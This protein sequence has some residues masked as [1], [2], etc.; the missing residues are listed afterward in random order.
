MTKCDKC[1]KNSYVI[2]IDKDHNKLCD[3][4]YDKKGKGI[5]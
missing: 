5:I 2:Y 3:K 4:C 1:G